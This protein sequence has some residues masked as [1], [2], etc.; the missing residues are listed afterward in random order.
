MATA[1]LTTWPAADRENVQGILDGVDPSIGTGW[2]GWEAH[3][4]PMLP[5]EP[6]GGANPT[7]YGRFGFQ[8]FTSI[9][10]FGTPSTLAP[11]RRRGLFL[12]VISQPTAPFGVTD[13]VFEATLAD[14][15]TGQG[16]GGLTFLFQEYRAPSGFSTLE[17]EPAG[18]RVQLGQLPLWGTS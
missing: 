2:E 10:A 1:T 11:V 13:D 6:S 4:V 16:T 3:G 15:V 12:W 14:L 9:P 7:V 18:F 17:T 5:P 8:D